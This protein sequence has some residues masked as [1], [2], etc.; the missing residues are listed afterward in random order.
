[1]TIGRRLLNWVH[2]LF[3]KPPLAADGD[4]VLAG[5]EDDVDQSAHPA[6]GSPS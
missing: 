3:V 6:E 2:D 1:M 5:V 4:E